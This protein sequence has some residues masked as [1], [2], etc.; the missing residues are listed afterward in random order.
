MDKN[1][2]TLEELAD[3]SSEKVRLS[4]HI[5]EEVLLISR[6]EKTMILSKSTEEIDKNA[7][8]IEEA[9]KLVEK[10]VA[11]L[12]A[13]ASPAEI[14]KLDSFAE[15]FAAYVAVNDQ[16]HDLAALNSNVKA[17]ATSKGAAH[18]AA[19]DSEAALK[20]LI[21]A[22]TRTPGV[23]HRAIELLKWE[24]LAEL[25]IAVR[26]EKNIV[27]ADNTKDMKTYAETYKIAKADTL[28]YASDLKR[29]SGLGGSPEAAKLDASLAAYFEASEQAQALSMENGNVRAFAISYSE[30][31]AALKATIEPLNELVKNNTQGMIAARTGAQEAYEQASMLLTAITG[32]AILIGVVAAIWISLAI[33]RGLSSAV[34]LAEAVAVGDLTK[35]VSATSRDEIGDLLSALQTMSANLRETA[36]LA[37][38][39]AKGD[40][41]V[42]ATP[43]SDK[44]TLGHSLKSMVDRL[45][46]VVSN[47]RSSS[48]NVAEGAQNLS[49]AAEQL[50]QGATEQAS[51]AQEASAAIEEMTA[52]IRQ[53][54]DN[55]S[56]TEKIAT[57]SAN[58]AQES[59]EAVDEAVQAMKTIADKIN[60]IQE[61]ARQ[62]D[63]L[64]LNAAVEAARAGQHGKGFA[65]VA[66]EVRKLAERSQ[67]AAGEISTL[68][69]D[70]V[71]VSQKAGEMLQTLVPNIQRTAELVQEISAS[72]REQNIGSG[73]IN[74]A[75]RELDQVIQQNA[76][77]SD[78]AASTSQEL[79]S[80]S[81]Q[82]RDVIG[83]FQVGDTGATGRG[84]RVI[85][86]SRKTASAPAAPAMSAN[87]A[88]A[89]SSGGVAIDL[90]EDISDAEFERY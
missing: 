55:A 43:R 33:S 12:R 35:N 78:E 64:A 65:V 17:R 71:E 7:A 72:Q 82:L 37:S 34:N 16:V 38:K 30:G 70:T 63:L 88:A 9:V 89:Q 57:Q 14:E 26:A 62:T 19:E 4:G 45:R 49:A 80:Q 32:V 74:T 61:I 76:A 25:L 90:S 73:Q 48:D 86:G 53:A 23:D 67:Q 31:A 47:A 8:E 51:A 81:D 27:L 40:L 13:L 11:K 24:V 50:S 41:S 68:S 5:K 84:L 52:N 79:A 75:I 56:Q 42:D 22:T 77:A 3:V 29:K 15:S 69:A 87:P 85:E 58:Q 10:D 54:A 21:K 2:R 6:D 39:I 18:E 59:G 20:S 36:D 83:F 44:D 28:K 46:Q 66:S 1:Q 60:I